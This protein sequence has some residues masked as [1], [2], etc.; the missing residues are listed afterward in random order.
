MKPRVVQK[1]GGTSIGTA[2]RMRS[3][4]EIIKSSRADDDV[5]V[6]ISAMS[7]Q[8]KAE[9]TTSLLLAAL[10]AAMAGADPT[11]QLE[12]IKT[13][14]QEAV[15][16]AI[17]GG[18]HA[19]DAR[20]FFAQ[21][22]QALEHFLGAISTIKEVSPRSHDAVVAV[23]ERLSARLLTAV[24]ESEG[25]P[26]SYVDLSRVCPE[27]SQQ[28]DQSFWDSVQKQIGL[29]VEPIVHEGRVPVLTGYLG[30]VP[31]GIIH[32]VGR[33]YTDFT[34]AL[35]AAALE[36][37]ELQIWKEVDGVYTT[38]PRKVEKAR[39]L[40]QLTPK[41]AAEL[42]YFGSEVVHPM[43][44]ER[45]I[46][47]GIPLRIKNTFRPALAGT[48]ISEEITPDPSPVKC[49][50]AKRNV[51]VLNIESNRMLMAYGFMAKLFRCF[52]QH[53][54]VIDLIATS[55]VNVSLTIERADRLG[56]VVRDLSELG[57][58]TV[59]RDMAIV[60]AVGQQ[61]KRSVGLAARMFGCL[62]R[63]GINI[64]MISQGASEI[65]ISCVIANADAE[66]A[67]RELHAEFLE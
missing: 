13:H 35:A 58:V 31:G 33:G 40:A 45:A 39:V 55:E 41:E 34:A 22:L 15:N 46:R 8:I 9:G 10:E 53:G 50:T 54:V 29:L 20:A 12:R 1:Y 3:V 32:A 36:C 43:T 63:A 52:E 42:T 23:G 62:G 59:T 48:V 47:A 17:S 30:P 60:S 38:D 21:E 4:V 49:V 56:D 44:M 51:T 14:H 16:N 6:A 19:D 57:E 11:V 66:R 37:R 67:L 25:V 27:N 28:A 61:M 65:N 18:P 5:I 64:E 24:L 7:S 2:E 26:A